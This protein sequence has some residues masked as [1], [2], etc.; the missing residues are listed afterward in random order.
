VFLGV[1]YAWLIITGLRTWW[2]DAIATPFLS[3]HITLRSLLVGWLAGFL[4][5]WLTIRLATRRFAQLPA[6]RLLAGDIQPSDHRRPGEAPSSWPRIREALVA[7]AMAL[8]IVGYL[9][10]NEAQAGVFFATGSVVLALLLGEVRYW[11]RV[12]ARNSPSRN[13]M[14]LPSLAALNTARHPGRSALTIGLVA[15]ATFLVAAISAF[16]LEATDEGTGGFALMATSDRPI[17]YDLNSRPGRIELGFSD[18]DQQALAG[19]TAFAFR[20]ADGEDASCLNLYRPTQPRVLGVPR[21]LVVRGGFAWADAANGETAK[22]NPW[23]LLDAD[24]GTDVA[25]R[26]IVPVALDANTATYSLQI[27]RVGKRLTIRDAAD[28]PVTLQV[29]GLLKNSVLQGSL[30]VSEANFLRMFPD[31]GGYRFFLMEGPGDAGRVAQI[32]EATLVADGFDAVDA[33]A[34]LAEFLAVQNTYLSTFQSLGALGLLLGTVGLAVVQLRNVFE[35][36]RE[37]ALMRA[38]GFRPQR[39]VAMVVLENGVLLLGGLLVGVL[40]AAVALAPQWAPR[41]AQVPWLTLAALFGAIAVVGLAAGWWATRS[42]LRAPI[43]GA[44]RGD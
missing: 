27:G 8:G 37:L 12:A 3:L 11:L 44:L 6:G 4:V 9:L 32:L 16:R 13:I 40:A 20:V 14:N 18:E 7:L 36:R 38:E 26:P 22:A 35:R 42:T 5:S 34:K 24:L 30:L 10:R 29:V 17:H 43:V 19:W 39:L 23:L 1:L 28:R 33:R 21:T 41:G 15:T 25:G 31:V 2:L